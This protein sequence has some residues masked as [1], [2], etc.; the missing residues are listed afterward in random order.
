MGDAVPNTLV[1]L[2]L[3]WNWGWPIIRRDTPHCEQLTRAPLRKT[4]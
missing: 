2:C 3:D 4:H 1:V